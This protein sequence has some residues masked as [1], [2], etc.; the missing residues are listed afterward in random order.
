MSTPTDQRTTAA[1]ITDPR[2]EAFLLGDAALT[3]V[4]GLAYLAAAP[5]LDDWFGAPVPLLRGLGAFLVVVAVGVATLARRHPVP[6]PGLLALVL[7]NTAW[8]MASLGYA[9]T[10]DLTTL[11][12]VWTVLQAVV[13]GAFAAAQLGLARRG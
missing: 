9:A 8:V 10:G 1:G 2:A 11:G 3:G 12:V 6:R 4:N 5:T 13:V 7:L